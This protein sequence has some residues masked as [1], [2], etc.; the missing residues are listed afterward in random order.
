MFFKRMMSALTAIV[1]TAGLMTGIVLPAKAEQSSIPDDVFI[2]K[3][4]SFKIYHEDESIFTKIDM[5]ENN[6]GMKD[7]K[8]QA[9]EDAIAS[10]LLDN[11]RAN[12]ETILTGFFGNAYDLKE[13][14]VT[15]K[16][17]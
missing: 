13:Y 16:D 3:A 14:E 9:E 7:L 8:Q 17:K 15:F 11:A 2:Y 1:I 10:G 5:T 4:H 12:V 6:E